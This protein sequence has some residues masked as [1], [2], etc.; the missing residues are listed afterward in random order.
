MKLVKSLLLGSAAGLVAVAGASAADLGV[1]KPTAVEYVKTCPTYG[2]GFFVVP[3]TT[4]CLKIGGRVR[5]DYLF[6]NDLVR[7][8]DKNTFRARGYFIY[9][10]RTATEYGL[11]RTFARG[12]FGRDNA[13]NNTSLEFAFVQLGGFT[14]GRQSALFEHGYS[15]NLIGSGSF[16]GFADLAFV[17]AASYVHNFG[18]GF[19]AG[20]S[21]E[22][23]VEHRTSL[24]GATSGGQSFPDIIGRISY[25]QSWGSL[26]LAGAVHESRIGAS[27][28][29]AAVV[30][31]PAVAAGA[32]VPFA[33][34][35]FGWAVTGAAKVNL[36]FLGAGS[37]AWVN[38]TYSE[39]ASSYAGYGSS[40]TIGNFVA[41]FSDATLV[42]AAPGVAGRVALTTAWSV[43]G[44]VQVFFTPTV[45][46]G[47]SGY[48]G[49]HDPAGVGNTLETYAGILTVGW[50]PAAGL[51]VAAEGVWQGIDGTR[52]FIPAG[53]D[54]SNFLG[55]IRI[56]RDF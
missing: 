30:G 47:L 13:T 49:N 56:Q 7:T 6:N 3:G 44:G 9:D 21:V 40:A 43:S 24:V 41:T 48:Y 54:R 38:G 16:G 12:Y 17:N 19:S 5:A 28:T 8:S 52:G 10:H 39:G 55:R 36:P 45:W 2:A 15:F 22:S 1:K 31:P 4:S 46:A 25:D 42:G 34:S 27:T 14:V 37:N 26:F 50:A 20:I 18:G 32:G 35:E 53:T 33:G 51:L 29:P 11:L 23:S